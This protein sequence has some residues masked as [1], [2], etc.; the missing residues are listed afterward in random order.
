MQKIDLRPKAIDITLCI[1]RMCMNKC[2][3][4]YEYWQPNENHQS[5]I[6][7][8]NEYDKYG[9]QKRCKSRLEEIK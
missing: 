2:K 1:N 6:N 9:K 5:Y 3:R 8:A 4:C 7:P